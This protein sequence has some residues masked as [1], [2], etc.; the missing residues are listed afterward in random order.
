MSNYATLTDLGTKVSKAGDTMTGDLTMDGTA[1]VIKVSD[2][3]MWKFKNNQTHLEVSYSQNSGTSWSVKSR[4]YA[5]QDKFYFL[6]NNIYA[7]NAN[8][9]DYKLLKRSEG[10]VRWIQINPAN[11][12]SQQTLVAGIP[13]IYSSVDYAALQL[14]QDPGNAEYFGR[15]TS[16]TTGDITVSLPLTYW[17]GDT[18]IVASHTYEFSIQNGSGHIIML[19]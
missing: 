3:Q 4:W 15:F 1:V 10:D 18:N 5:T 13:N 2:T 6:C 8:D 16:S 7:G 19:S 11:T 17:T 14:P 12:N 9:D